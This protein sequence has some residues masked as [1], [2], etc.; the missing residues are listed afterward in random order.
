MTLLLDPLFSSVAFGHMIVDVLNGMRPVLLTYWAVQLGMSNASLAL[1]STVYVWVASLSQPLFGWLTDRL[2][3]TRWTAAGGVLWLG[4]FFALALFLPPQLGIPCLLLASLGSGAFH[5]AGASQATTRGRQGLAQRETTAAAWFFMFGQTGYFFGPILGGP[6][7][8]RFGAAGLLLPALATLP[9]GLNTAG[10]L[11]KESRPLS[12]EQATGKSGKDLVSQRGFFLALALVAALQAWAQQNM[13]TFLPKYLHDLGQSP[14]V[15]GLIAGLFMGG[16]ALGNVMGGNLAD[17]FGK[18]RVAAVM[19][20]LATP[21]LFILSLIGWSGWV[22]VLTPLAG[23]LTGAVHSIIVVLAQ[24]TIPAGS[25][26]ASGLILGFMFSAGA[27]GT[28]LSGPLADA[29]GFI[30]V[31]QMTAGLTLAASLLTFQL[32]ETVAATQPT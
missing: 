25:G 17:R 13:I 32:R 2:G 3:S 18:Q 1:V 10:Q 21:P 11:R 22:Y 20:A 12:V 24:R 19:L 9:L 26:L 27:L 30:P 8:D 6:L 23:L 7:L 14:T 4:G 15:Y 28:L 31:F 16:S 5:P 29:Q